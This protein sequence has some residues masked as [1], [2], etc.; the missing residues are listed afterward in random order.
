MVH[1]RD[2]VLFEVSER[3]RYDPLRFEQEKDAARENLRQERLGQMLGS[4]IAQ[5]REEMGVQYDTQLLQNFA[6]TP[7]EG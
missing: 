4:I 3:H 1:D 2:L 7:G 6:A 5:R